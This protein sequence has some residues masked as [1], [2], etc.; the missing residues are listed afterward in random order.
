MN[1]Y[2]LRK[3]GLFFVAL[4]FTGIGEGILGL[5]WYLKSKLKPNNSEEKYY[6]F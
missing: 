4:F 5:F 2:D 6:N 3:Y 1:K